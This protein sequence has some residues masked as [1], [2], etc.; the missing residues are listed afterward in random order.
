MADRPILFS[1]PMVR[2]LLDGRKTQTRRVM[3]QTPPDW[4]SHSDPGFSVLTPRGH[5]EFRG[6]FEG[7]YAA[8]FIKLP[9][10]NG[11]RLW[12]R[13]AWRTSPTY[14][15]LKPSDMGG[16]ESIFF[17]ADGAWES[18]G[19]G[20]IGCVSGGRFRQGIHMP[21]WAS[22][23]TLTVTRVRVQRLQE[24][25]NED[26]KAEGVEH[27]QDRARGRVIGWRD[28]LNRGWKCGTATG[29]FRSLWDSLNAKRAP[30]E[31]NPWV[32][33]YT[34]TVARGNIDA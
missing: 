22:R 12:V 1:G 4:C 34:F 13:E 9:F 33:A 8:A 18:W 31:S 7:E 14:D 15:D 26:A 5:V 21:R 16:D 3:K 24:I 29:S 28:Y 20:D 25:S 17:E 32:V 23:L 11:D 30:W 27:D 10:W 2:A 6:Q 19:W